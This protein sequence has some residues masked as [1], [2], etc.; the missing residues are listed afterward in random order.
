MRRARTIAALPLLLAACA[1]P[2]VETA[3][4]DPVTPPQGW[5]TSLGQTGV[6][7]ANWWRAFGDPALPARASLV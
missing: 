5:R 6:L 7:D 4:V 1:G 2:R 3:R